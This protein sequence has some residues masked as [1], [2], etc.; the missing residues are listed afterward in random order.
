MS[1]PILEDQEMYLKVLYEVQ[2][3]DAESPIRTNQVAE[4]M[5]VTA[6][7]ASEMLKRLGKK[8]FLNHVPY[9]GVTLTEKGLEAASRVKRREALMEVFLVQM[10]DFKGDIKDVACRLEHA[11]TDE[12]ESAIDRLLGFP[13]H[14]PDGSEIPQRSREITTGIGSVLLP[15]SALPEGMQSTVELL[16]FDGV[17]C[18]T[19]G[20]SGIT[21]DA[22][23]ER[24]SG[25]FEIDG[26]EMVISKSLQSRILVR[27]N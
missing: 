23:I 21:V 18:K 16:V 1:S 5:S 13:S 11:L 20:D 15:L 14:A 7:S 8:G 25:G 12:L 9:K 17:D 19:L 3:I 6:A 2:L 4:A 10:L 27:S 22:K 24:T 26:V